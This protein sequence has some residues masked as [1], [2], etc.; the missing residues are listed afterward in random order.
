V[1][2]LAEAVRKQGLHFGASI[3]PSIGGS[4]TAA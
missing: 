4:T 3:A 1:R 2:E